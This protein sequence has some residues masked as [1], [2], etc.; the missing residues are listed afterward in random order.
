MQKTW[1]IWICVLAACHSTKRLGKHAIETPVQ[2]STLHAVDV[3]DTAMHALAT[4]QKLVDSLDSRWPSFTTADARIKLSYTD[5][6]QAADLSAH[7][8]MI[9]DSITWINVT[10]PFNFEVMRLLAVND[11]VKVIDRLHKTYLVRPF[12][13][14]AEI[15]GIPFTH[16]SFQSVLLGKPFINDS[17]VTQVQHY[18]ND[19][20]SIVL[21]GPGSAA[22]LYLKADEKQPGQS[23]FTDSARMRTVSFKYED[24]RSTGNGKFPFECTANVTNYANLP[25]T[26][27]M[28]IFWTVK[29]IAF[30]RPVEYLFNQPENYTQQ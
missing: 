3:Q 13:Y 6:N 8:V 24:Y 11:T 9:K 5:Q 1:L 19:L 26:L 22:Q 2:D 28:E 29:E 15:S 12:S 4:Y 14:L 21:S 27:L 17:V 30:N 10:G 23:V 18:E 16:H 7:I 25:A 20:Y